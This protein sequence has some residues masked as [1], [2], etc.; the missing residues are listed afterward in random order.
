[1]D[2]VMSSNTKY[3]LILWSVSS[4]VWNQDSRYTSTRPKRFQIQN[5]LLMAEILHQFR[6]VVYPTIFRVSGPSNNI[7]LLT[8]FWITIAMLPHKKTRYAHQKDETPVHPT[9]GEWNLAASGHQRITCPVRN[10]LGASQPEVR[11]Q[12]HQP[13]VNPC[14]SKVF[15]RPRISYTLALVQACAHG[16]TGNVLVAVATS[17]MNAPLARPPS[18]A[19]GPCICL[20]W[21]KRTCILFVAVLFEVDNP[22]VS[23]TLSKR[24]SQRTFW[25]WGHSCQCQWRSHSRLAHSSGS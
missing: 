17:C 9:V 14:G 12:D 6:L 7:V 22:K 1:M 16:W 11:R 23:I 19:T 2:R 13:Q 21:S 25:F 8:N 24:G 5:I 15:T 4:S 10:H 18:E 20:A 3:C